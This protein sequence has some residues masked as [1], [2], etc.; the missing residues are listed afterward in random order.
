MCEER[1]FSKKYNGGA[2]LVLHKRGAKIKLSTRTKMLKKTCQPI[3]NDFLFIDFYV[4]LILY[5]KLN[6]MS[7][8]HFLNYTII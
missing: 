4:F 8:V 3:K 7:V 5:D 2:P 6:V 1:W